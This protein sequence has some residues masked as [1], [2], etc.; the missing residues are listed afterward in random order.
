M[1]VAIMNV[2]ISNGIA[3]P[4]GMSQLDVKSNI[5]TFYEIV[6]VYSLGLSNNV[7]YFAESTLLLLPF[8]NLMKSVLFACAA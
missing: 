6:Y 3:G 5:N 1:N 7:N 2:F 8:F 4:Q